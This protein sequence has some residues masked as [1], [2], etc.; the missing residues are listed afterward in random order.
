MAVLGPWPHGNPMPLTPQERERLAE[1]EAGLRGDP[2]FLRGH[3]TDERPRQRIRQTVAA[4]V[5]LIGIALSVA[6]AA[7]A[8]HSFVVGFII[9]LTGFVV[10]VSG[11]VMWFAVGD[12]H[13]A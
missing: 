7:I 12:R 1:I 3:A 2:E 5:M 13:N 10:V 11:A 9:V 8:P 4:A 6:G